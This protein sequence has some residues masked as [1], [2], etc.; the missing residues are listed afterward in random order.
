[1][2]NKKETYNK[3]FEYSKNKNSTYYEIEN[4]YK[5]ALVGIDKKVYTE[6][7][8]NKKRY[9]Y[10]PKQAV[11]YAMTYA[12][13][14]NPSYPNYTGVGGDCAN[15]V[16]QCLYAGG[17]PMVGWSSTNLNNWFC[18]SNNKWNTNLISSTWRGARAFSKFWMKNANEFKDFGRE[19]FRSLEDFHDVYSYGSRGDVVSF[20]D[21]YRVAYHTLIIVDYNNGDLICASHTYNSNSRELFKDNP[22]GGVRIYKMS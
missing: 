21:S 13:T 15:F 22:S 11:E 14:Y 10:N 7:E 12:L 8:K 18:R 1:M 20:L 3:I 9:P 5:N 16:S 19:Y 17:K 6:S 4:I 2:K